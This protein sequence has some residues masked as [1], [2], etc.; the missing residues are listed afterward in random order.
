MTSGIRTRV[1]TWSSTLRV[2]MQ[3]WLSRSGQ[4]VA[5]RG[6]RPAPFTAQHLLEPPCFVARQQH[7]QR[8]C[9]VAVAD[10][11]DGVGALT[12][13]AFEIPGEIP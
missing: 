3:S 13:A 5:H 11:G 9:F 2:E 1:Q 8:V 6:L 7:G 4:Q 12:F 10:L